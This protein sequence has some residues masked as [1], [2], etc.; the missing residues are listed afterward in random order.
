MGT[1]FCAGFIFA[2]FISYADGGKPL[3]SPAAEFPTHEVPRASRRLLRVG[4]E[5][6]INFWRTSS[7]IRINGGHGLLKPS[8]A[9]LR[10]ASI[11]SFVPIAILLLA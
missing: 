8:P 11:P 5:Q 2:K 7:L 1:C 9:S 10:V 4:F 6:R 3:I